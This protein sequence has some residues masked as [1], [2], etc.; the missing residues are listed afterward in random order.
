M[1]ALNFTGINGLLERYLFTFLLKRI[2]LE[3]G[4]PEF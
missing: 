4:K 3:F 1:G 2:Q